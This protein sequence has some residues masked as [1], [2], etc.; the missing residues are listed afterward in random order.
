MIGINE[1]ENFKILPNPFTENTTI[2]FHLENASKI[3]ISIYNLQGE[4]INTLINEKKT[5]G[6]YKIIWNGKDKNGKEVNSG[7]YFVR[8]NSGR[9]IYTQ[10][11]VLLK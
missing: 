9:N 6:E 7:L 8:L 11:V 10:K 1:I 3:N 4:L 2:N 5:K